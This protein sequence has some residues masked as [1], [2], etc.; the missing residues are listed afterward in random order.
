MSVRGAMAMAA[1][2]AVAL[3]VFGLI[4]DRAGPRYRLVEVFHRGPNGAI[5]VAE[6]MI[7]DLN[8]PADQFHGLPDGETSYR[9]KIAR[10]KADTAVPSPSRGGGR[11]GRGR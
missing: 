1:V 7:F 11:R 4:R 6:R 10:L 5:D 8:A 3:F 2:V 9:R